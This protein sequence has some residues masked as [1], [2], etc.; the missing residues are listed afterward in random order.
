MET[1]VLVPVG[2]EGSRIRDL[3]TNSKSLRIVGGRSLLDQ[4]L[5]SIESSLPESTVFLSVR[6]VTTDWERFV[7]LHAQNLKVRLLLVEDAENCSGNLSALPNINLSSFERLI[8]IFPDVLWMG[9][10]ENA[11]HLNDSSDTRIGVQ[12]S[13]FQT[14]SFTAP[15][16]E[17][18]KVVAFRHVD[19]A[20]RTPLTLAVAP[21][22]DV[23]VGT[24]V[25]PN[26]AEGYDLLHWLMKSTVQHSTVYPFF[27]SYPILDVGSGLGLKAAAE[28]EILEKHYRFHL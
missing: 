18:N 23:P 16:I 6:Q 21:F 11:L 20:D 22:I 2:G 1:A 7:E 12:S 5:N 3:G 4:V 13:I 8:V 24:I 14:R 15:I 25:M 9:Q 27:F 19:Y 17:G 10:L 28:S 26:R